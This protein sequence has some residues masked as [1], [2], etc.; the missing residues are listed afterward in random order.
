MIR[1]P[2]TETKEKARRRKC[3]C[4]A[5]SSSCQRCRLPNKAKHNQS[6]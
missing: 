1:K 3:W 2:G 4:T 5:P 6:F